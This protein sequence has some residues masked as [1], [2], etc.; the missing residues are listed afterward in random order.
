MT[1]SFYVTINIQQKEHR[2][3]LAN[4]IV[5]PENEN[6][7]VGLVHFSCDMKAATAANQTPTKAKYW[8]SERDVVTQWPDFVLNAIGS[9]HDYYILI[10]NLHKALLPQSNYTWPMLVDVITL[11]FNNLT[12][13]EKLNISIKF[14]DDNKVIFQRTGASDKTKAID[15]KFST[16]FASLLSLYDGNIPLPASTQSVILPFTRPVVLPKSDDRMAQGVFKLPE[17]SGGG[18]YSIGVSTI[19]T[20][21]ATKNNTIVIPTGLWTFDE[22]KK[23]LNERLRESLLSVRF[24][25]NYEYSNMAMFLTHFFYGTMQF[26]NGFNENNT[27]VITFDKNIENALCIS[28]PYIEINGNSNEYFETEY[29]IPLLLNDEV[30]QEYT[31]PAITYSELNAQQRTFVFKE[32]SIT[33]VKPAEKHEYTNYKLKVDDYLGMLLGIGNNWIHFDNDDHEFK[34][35]GKL[36]HPQEATIIQQQSC[37]VY[38]DI[39]QENVPTDVQYKLLRHVSS[40]AASIIYPI[41][42]LKVNQNR[43]NNINIKID[44]S[45]EVAIDSATI[46]LHFMKQT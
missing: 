5:L 29:R 16:E 39:I 27:R 13:R 32:K 44:A 40:A 14:K 28:K 35:S 17:L 23:Y 20:G 3:I 22:F 31:A 15:L 36:I 34:C 11:N 6:W 33:L 24:P 21:E 4:E 26:S 19:K 18:Q 9:M 25:L 30:V 42:Y 10:N 8:I 43:I 2:H 45:K 46:V 37:H 1:S 12:K 41:I 38:T 7:H